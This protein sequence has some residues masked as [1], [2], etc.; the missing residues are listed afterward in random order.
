M[1]N[2]TD[3]WRHANP[4]PECKYSFAQPGDSSRSRIDHI[5]TTKEIIS[6]ASDWTIEN[7]EIPTDHQLVTVRLYDENSPQVGHGCW[8]MRPFILRD[9]KFINSVDQI[10]SESTHLLNNPDTSPQLI[11]Q[12]FVEQ[13]CTLAQKQSKAKAGIIH[14]KTK[15]LKKA[16]EKLINKTNTLEGDELKSSLEAAS[17][18]ARKIQDAQSNLFDQNQNTTRANRQ[19]LGETINKY[20]CTNRKEK[21]A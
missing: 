3:G 17:M 12:N 15:K 18:I 9:K 11:L 20:W 4:P 8:A 7:P 19:L 14:S 1:L 5:Y 6:R 13:V 10:S 16:K 2:L 21:K